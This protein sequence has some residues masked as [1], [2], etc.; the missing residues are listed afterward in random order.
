MKVRA[1]IFVNGKV[2][3]VFFRS[4][5]RREAKKRG[6]KGW[7]RNLSDGKVEAVFEGEEE[8]VKQLIDFCKCGPPGARVMYV[9]VI[10]ENYTGDF[11]D[12]EI[13]YGYRF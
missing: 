9:N 10:W 4:E 8:N 3:G 5:T 1:H 12:F 6:V 7:I 13:R 11:K 2:Q